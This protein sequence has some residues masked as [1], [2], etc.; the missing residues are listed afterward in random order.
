MVLE[1][2]LGRSQYID[3]LTNEINELNGDQQTRIERYNP[4]QFNLISL[5]IYLNV[6]HLLIAYEPK[7]SFDM[8]LKQV[9][10]C[11]GQKC[12]DCRKFYSFPY[13]VRL[14]S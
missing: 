9:K 13:P 6:S 7:V 11:W 5:P 10:R 2:D 8:R 12:R 4:F 3:T 14:S 1:P